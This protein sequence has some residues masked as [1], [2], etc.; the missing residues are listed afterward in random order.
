[1]AE[2]SEASNVSRNDRSERGAVVDRRAEN[3]DTPPPERSSSLKSDALANAAANAANSFEARRK[4]NVT[5]LE[6]NKAKRARNLEISGD[7]MDMERRVAVDLVDVWTRHTG[8]R[9]IVLNDGT[10]A[11]VLLGMDGTDSFLP[12][13]LKT[14]GAQYTGRHDWAFY[15]VQKYNGMPVVCWRC[16]HADCWVFDGGLLHERGKRELA[17]SERSSYA[18]LARAS[19]LGMSDLV[20]YLW[21]HAHD[22]PLTTE[23]AA[24]HDFENPNCATEMRG[25]DAYRNLFGDHTFA[26]PVQQNSSVIMTAV[27]GSSSRH[28][29]RDQV[30]ADFNVI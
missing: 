11:D 23:D 12:V 26:W 15:H 6:D 16:D 14:T 28:F 29:D 9:A 13:Q 17:I 27:R 10:R 25:I 19:N 2:E 30:V 21:Q 3:M 4:R 18:K 5:L 1:M 20:S 7:S 22:W 24:R 8:Y